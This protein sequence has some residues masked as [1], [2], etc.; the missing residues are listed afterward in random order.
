MSSQAWTMLTPRGLTP[1]G[2]RLSKT[3][4]VVRLK[5]PAQFERALDLYFKG[6]TATGRTSGEGGGARITPEDV[7][8]ALGGLADQPFQF[9]MAA[10]LDDARSKRLVE[11]YLVQELEWMAQAG[12]WLQSR[13]DFERLERVASLLVFE[14]ISARS[15]HETY[16]DE[17][18]LPEGSA[19]IRCPR[20]KG[21]GVYDD[22]RELKKWRRYSRIIMRARLAEE[23]VRT[24]GGGLRKPSW[25][26]HEALLEKARLGTA[27]ALSIECDWCENSGRLLITETLRA[28]RCGIPRPTWY[29]TW[30]ARYAEAM[31]IPLRWENTA[32]HHVR[33]KLRLDERDTLT[34]HLGLMGECAQR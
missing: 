21:H 8:A 33:R 32:V 2:D 27:A 14:A 18:K 3:T 28:K 13:Q 20:C 10:F 19:A 22:L 7:K 24:A 15:R 23:R 4:R 9:G 17:E 29:R 5:P 34:H 30:Q 16:G 26:L 11:G 1:E 12:G 25:H 6:R 31:A